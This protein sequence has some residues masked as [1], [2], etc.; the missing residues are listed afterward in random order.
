MGI[1]G[2]ADHAE[3][4][5]KSEIRRGDTPRRG[6]TDNDTHLVI[7]ATPTDRPS[8]V[9]RSSLSLRKGKL[10]PLNLFPS[11]QPTALNDRLQPVRQALGGA[12]PC[13]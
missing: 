6:P 2:Q 5:N 3:T 10:S 12:H 11:H 8:A 9:T 7:D 13:Q 1:I 4:P